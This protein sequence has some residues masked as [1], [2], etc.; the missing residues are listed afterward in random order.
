MS[1]SRA[2][3]P[4]RQSRA[5]AGRQGI[6]SELLAPLGISILARSAQ[7]V[8]LHNDLHIFMWIIPN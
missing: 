3:G 1:N 6:R 8:Y 2:D 4:I 5:S 7:I